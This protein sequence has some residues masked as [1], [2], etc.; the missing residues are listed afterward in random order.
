MSG[1]IILSRRDL[2]A[3]LRFGDYVEAVEEGFR[4]LAEGGCVA[5]LPMHI[6]VNQV[7]FHVKAASLPRGHGYVA[8][9]INAN[10]PENRAR[11]GLPTIQGAILLSD[12]S[13]GT[14]LALL[15]SIEIT[16][17]R[18]GAATAVAAKYLARP[19]SGTATICGCGEQG[20]IQLVALRHVLDLRRVFAWDRDR[21]VA[22]A[23]ARTMSDELGI[24]VEAVTELDAATSGSDVIVTCTSAR[25]PFLDLENVRPGT[26]IAA[27]GADNPEKNEI[28][29]ALMAR[30]TVVA[31]V[32]SQC[33]VMG[34]LH[35]A[36][37]TGAMS[38][39]DVHAEL[40]QLVTGRKRGRASTEE[41]TLFDAT[42]TGLQDVAA[43]ARAYEAARARG[44]GLV[45]ELGGV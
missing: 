36:I 23:Y 44:V 35:H 45:C 10:F 27:V 32:L 17:Q 8:V 5:P 34:D 18:T 2:A 1:L 13:N 22:D 7:G 33:V 3:L 31:D 25:E 4:L 26:F 11:A 16:I 24:A 15:D 20:R 37:R 6:P 43:A 30:A 39:R 28:A 41:V 9:K 38:P 40:A 21:K 19:E 14:P 42:G 12:A 29:A